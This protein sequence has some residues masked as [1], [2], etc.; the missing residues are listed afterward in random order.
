MASASSQTRRSPTPARSERDTF[1]ARLLGTAISLLVV[2]TVVQH[3]YPNRLSG[4]VLVFFM[5]AAL[6]ATWCLHLR[7]AGL[8]HGWSLTLGVLSVGIVWGEFHHIL[9][10]SLGACWSALGSGLFVY[11]MV[12]VFGM[13]EREKG[14]QGLATAA[15]A[16]SI[17]ML[18]RPPVILGC[19]L[20]SLILFVDERRSWG[21]ALSS[22]L[23]LL[24]PVLLCAVLLGF[25]SYFW[26]GGVLS[27][28]WNLGTTGNGGATNGE[29]GYSADLLRETATFIFVAGILAVRLFERRSGKTDLALV[30]LML[31][32][33][34]VGGR[35]W[36]P[37]RLS[38]DEVR[39][40]L[41][42]GAASLLASSPPAFLAERLLVTATSVAALIIDLLR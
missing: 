19:V 25:L 6:A 39:F 21:S 11:L 28:L 37:G 12:W 41:T 31:T 26:P 4:S 2:S 36:M 30:F 13:H 34:A 29:G 20:L 5:A 22:L 42:C 10:G 14:L 15:L 8:P 38:A 33:C 17:G 23:L 16:L 32:I 7:D 18:A 24:T 27:T 1:W 9:V 3:L 35:P 40:I